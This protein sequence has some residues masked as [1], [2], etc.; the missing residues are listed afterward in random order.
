MTGLAA[1]SGTGRWSGCSRRRRHTSLPAS[2]RCYALPQ[3]G[4]FRAQRTGLLEQLQSLAPQLFGLA[5]QGLDLLSQPVL[6]AAATAELL[7]GKVL[8]Q[9]QPVAPHMSGLAL[10]DLHL[11]SQCALPALT[12]AELLAGELLLA[13]EDQQQAAPLFSCGERVL[14]GPTLLHVWRPKREDRGPRGAAAIARAWR[15]AV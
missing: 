15:G 11:L 1:P 7:A 14:P 6:R 12:A 9:L 10:Q 3:R 13:G 4:I 8:Q 2:H 5:L